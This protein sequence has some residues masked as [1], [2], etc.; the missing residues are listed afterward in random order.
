[1]AYRLESFPGK[2][3][4]K[5]LPRRRRRS[6]SFET[7]LSEVRNLVTAR[8]GLAS[9]VTVEEVSALLRARQGEVQKTFYQLVR[10]GILSRAVNVAPHDSTRDAFLEGC[11]P[12][13]G[14]RRGMSG[15]RPSVW[16]FRES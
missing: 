9:G 4:E 1:M 5:K 15:W 3:E 6:R 7:L 10:E 14:R 8:Q 12:L 11:P 13:S 16:P 2:R